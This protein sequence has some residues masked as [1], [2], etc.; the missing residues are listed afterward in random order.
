MSQPQACSDCGG[1]LEIGIL[2]D[3]SMAAALQSAWHRGEPDDKTIL[4]YLK[5]GP[6]VK[7]ERSQLIPIRALRC[8]NCGVLA[9]YAKSP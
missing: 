9:M 4:D 3:V 6:G 1:E 8:T 2:P 7:Y 5:L